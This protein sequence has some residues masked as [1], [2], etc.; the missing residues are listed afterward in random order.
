MVEVGLMLPDEAAGF[1]PEATIRFAR[2]AE[3]AG[4]H[5]VWK[6]EASWGNGPMTLAAIARETD[7]IR[8]ATGI[9]NVYS[10][11]PSLLAMTAGTL[12]SLSG[13]RTVL[14][15]GASSEPVVE[16]WH[17]LAFDRPLR[18]TRETIEILRDS[19]DGGTLEY[20]G[21]IFD[22]GPYSIGFDVERDSVPIY[23]AAMGETNCRLTGEYA[24]G[25]V[26]AFVPRRELG[27]LRDA[28]AAGA[29]AADRDPDEITVAPMV[30]TAVAEDPAVAESHVRNFLARE[31][32]MGYNR[33]AEK[34]GFGQAADEA[35]ERW[36]DGD[37]EGAAAAITREMLDELAIYGTADQCREQV[38]RYADAGCDVVV[39]FPPFSAPAEITN[40]IIDAFATDGTPDS[41]DVR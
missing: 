35:F 23:N 33:L 15:L 18:R 34:Y 12:E 16:R 30:G 26:P 24:D 19:F 3:A 10:R 31:M 25:W 9:A 7:E 27:T 13:G 21:E 39:F 38:T 40:D 29:R 4:F 8:L 32:A 41:E 20:E 2:R 17:G 28:V 11:T 5:S 6:G 37:R 1:A 36:R 22:V 14:G